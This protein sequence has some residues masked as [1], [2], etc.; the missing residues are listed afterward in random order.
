MNH[1]LG[2]LRKFSTRVE[3]LANRRVQ[4]Q[5]VQVLPNSFDELLDMFKST[6]EFTVR[7]LTNISKIQRKELNFSVLKLIV[8]I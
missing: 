1:I 6:N 8:T 3:G 7:V 2:T 5:T 4:K